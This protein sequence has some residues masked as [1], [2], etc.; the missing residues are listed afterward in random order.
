MEAP[1]TRALDVLIYCLVSAAMLSVVLLL[2]VW[3]YRR[4]KP[5]YGNVEVREELRH[6]V[7]LCRY[8]I[9]QVQF[10]PW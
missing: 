4:R 2:A 9:S 8:C 3:M 7:A 1:P 6:Q 5:L 10:D